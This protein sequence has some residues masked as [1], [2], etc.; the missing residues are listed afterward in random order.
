VLHAE[1]VRRGPYLYVADLGLSQNGT[2]VNGRPVTRC[3][4]AAG[5]VVC[6]GTAM[7]QAGGITA[8]PAAAPVPWKRPDLTPREAEVL[9]ALCQHAQT[10][11]AFTQPAPARQIARQLGVTEAAIKQHLLRLY[12]KFA[13]SP[14][15]DRRT[16]LANAA[17]ALGLAA[18]PLPLTRS[19]DL[20]SDPGQPGGPD[21]WMVQ[22]LRQG[23]G[24][25]A[26]AEAAGIGPA[27]ARRR[28]QD[29]GAQ[30]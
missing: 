26:I 2:T 22:A 29:A 11:T 1:L 15:P 30:L 10:G 9:A 20:A 3:L 12:D 5:D 27:Q 28:L 25:D 14:G 18:P 8:G 16:R 19:P 4:L 17:A 6:F 24:I 7:C 13:I 23:A 21:G